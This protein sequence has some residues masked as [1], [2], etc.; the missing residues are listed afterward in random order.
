MSWTT[1]FPAFLAKNH[2]GS[3]ILIGCSNNRSIQIL[4]IAMTKHH[5]PSRLPHITA[6]RLA[7]SESLRVSPSLSCLTRCEIT[8]R[9]PKP[10][11]ETPS[12]FETRSLDAPAA[13]LGIRLA[14]KDATAKNLFSSLQEN[15]SLQQKLSQSWASQSLSK[16]G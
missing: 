5:S 13:T 7:A 4:L 11:Q 1:T 2:C 9:S 15:I 16:K 6:H 3:C 8:T 10:Y 12:P 14:Q